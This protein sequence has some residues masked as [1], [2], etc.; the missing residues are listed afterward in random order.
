MTITPDNAISKKTV[1]NDK[2]VYKSGIMS[3]IQT[4]PDSECSLL[5]AVYVSGDSEGGHSS[6]TGIRYRHRGLGPGVMF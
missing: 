2:T 1:S 5:I 4:S 6:P 3:S